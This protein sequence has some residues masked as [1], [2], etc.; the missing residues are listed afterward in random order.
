MSITIQ[1]KHNHVYRGKAH[2]AGEIS[3]VDP[4]DYQTLVK[5]WLWADKYVEPVPEVKVKKP[6]SEPQPEPKAIPEIETAALVEP[7]AERA[8][9]FTLPA[10]KK[11]KKSWQK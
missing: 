11:E 8:V 2:M 1:W 4:S 10:K 6:K 3:E 9:L 5:A 7:E